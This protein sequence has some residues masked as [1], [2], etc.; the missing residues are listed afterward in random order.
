LSDRCLAAQQRGDEAQ[1]QA[2]VS[3]F[4]D[5][6]EWWH[7]WVY[8]QQRRELFPAGRDWENDRKDHLER[9]PTQTHGA[10][11]V[12]RLARSLVPV[13]TTITRVLPP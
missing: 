5:W 6:C 3:A 1:V 2:A 12:E 9:A 4:F 10:D 11:T 13:S 7:D 8:G